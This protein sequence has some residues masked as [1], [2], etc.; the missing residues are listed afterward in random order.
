MGR[1]LITAGVVLVLIGLLAQWGL[2]IGRLPGDIRIQRGNS[3]FYL[4]IA[5]CIV[6]SVVLSVIGMLMRR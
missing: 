3:T 2:P 4:P 5:T 1:L 6:I